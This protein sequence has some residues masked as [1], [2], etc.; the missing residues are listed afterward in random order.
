MKS[1]TAL[2]YSPRLGSAD[3]RQPTTVPKTRRLT[4]ATLVRRSQQ[5]DRRAFAVLAGRYDWRLRG[6]AHALLLDRAEMDT[7]LG[8]AYL[9]AWRDVVRINVKEDVGAWLYRV[10]YN[11]CID[12]LR[13]RDSPGELSGNAVAAG[14]ASLPAADRVAVVLVD[15]EGFTPASAARIL[16]LTPTALT[17]RLGAARERLAGYLPR[18]ETEATPPPAEAGGGVAGAAS[19]EG[20][21]AVPPGDEP[22]AAALAGLGE[23]GAPGGPAGA[24]GGVAG[25]AS[26]EGGVAVPPGDERDAA[27]RR[28]AGP[29]ESGATGE[30]PESG[31]VSAGGG[32]DGAHAN[33]HDPTGAADDGDATRRRGDA[34]SG[35][36]GA[37]DCSS[38]AV[39][40]GNGEPDR[41]DADRNGTAAGTRAAGDGESSN[42]RAGDAEVVDG[43]APSGAGG[44]GGSVGEVD[45]GN[46]GTGGNDDGGKGGTGGNDDG[47]KGGTGGEVDGGNGGTV[48]NDDG[49][50]GHA[51]NRGRGRRARRRA[52]HA[53]SQPSTDR[54]DP[55][56]DAAP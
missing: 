20:G 54:P 31:A 40:A 26:A 15:R 4:D 56:G 30:P 25:A 18:P 6:L 48:G 32:V 16:G 14:L 55:N 49:G 35:V 5:G 3:E 34:S 24:G 28:P 37:S 39:A 41:E 50:N 52:K 44:N 42:G 33:G 21:V 36:G 13:R 8:L 7:A 17:T 23:A 27:A 46:G 12:Q 1:P 51:S 47:G 10:T 2:P 45:G 19:A 22:E 29:E 53:A 38:P 43:T 11:A 9:R